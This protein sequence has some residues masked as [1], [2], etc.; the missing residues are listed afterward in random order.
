MPAA[1]RLTRLITT[2]A[3][4]D[5][6]RKLQTTSAHSP[7][8]LKTIFSASPSGKLSSMYSSPG[9]QA[10]TSLDGRFCSRQCQP[11]MAMPSPAVRKIKTAY[12]RLP[13]PF[14]SCKAATRNARPSAMT[15]MRCST[16]SGHGSRRRTYCA[17]NA[18]PI[19]PAQ[20][21]K[22]AKFSRR[23]PGRVMMSWSPITD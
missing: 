23:G 11:A 21:R 8:P 12:P 2:H 17:N 19:N 4:I 9:P 7:E 22:P 3:G 13:H 16:H 14:E 5:R 10:G 6:P 1:P 20:H 18:N 15:A